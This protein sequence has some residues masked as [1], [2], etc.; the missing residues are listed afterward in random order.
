M[1]HFAALLVL[2]A[3]PA[4]AD[5]ARFS[6][7]E[8]NELV[9]QAKQE[10]LRSTEQPRKDDTQLTNE[11]RQSFKPLDLSFETSPHK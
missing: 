3:S 11:L 1:R 5:T 6:K 2:I 7:G 10:M 9:A 4:F 8:I